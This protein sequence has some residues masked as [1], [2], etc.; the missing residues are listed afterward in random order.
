MNDIY[1]NFW[2]KAPVELLEVPLTLTDFKK[3]DGSY[4]TVVEYQAGLGHT[5]DRI[6]TDGYFIKGFSFN[7]KGLKELE[8]KASQFGLEI[9]KNLFIFTINEVQKELEKTEWNKLEGELNG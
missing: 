6:S 2:V 3:E 9:G 8:D 5:I 7:Y 4:M 1:H